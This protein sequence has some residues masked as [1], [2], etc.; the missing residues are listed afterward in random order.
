MSFEPVECA[1][2]NCEIVFVP[3][4]HNMIYHNDECCKIETN[5]RTK[6]KYYS[7]KARRLGLERICK[8]CNYTKLSRYNESLICQACETKLQSDLK[9]S[10]LS[11]LESVE[12]V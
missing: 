6:E 12:W 7:D 1:Q 2:R 10:V 9:R 3:H 8:E 5:L 11:M 4:R